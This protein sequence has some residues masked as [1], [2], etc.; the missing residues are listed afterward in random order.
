[1]TAIWIH[2]TQGNTIC[3]MN[4]TE[5]ALGRKCVVTGDY[6]YIAMEFIDNIKVTNL[7]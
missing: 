7:I 5:V 4:T 1:M 2:N 3:V 6:I